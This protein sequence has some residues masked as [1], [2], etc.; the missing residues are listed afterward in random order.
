MT[1]EGVP[2]NLPKW[3]GFVVLVAG[4]LGLGTGLCAVL[5]LVATAVQGWQEH[6]QA[7]WP[8]ATAQVKRCGVDIYTHKPKRYW[9]DCS[10]TY[11]VHGKDIMA[12]TFIPAARAIRNG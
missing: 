2:Q 7:Q 11:Q 6:A 1:T 4:F 10:I 12:H 3:R 8:K 5:A 9:I